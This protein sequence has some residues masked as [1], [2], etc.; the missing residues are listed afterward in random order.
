MKNLSYKWHPLRFASKLLNSNFKLLLPRIIQRS[1]K[2]GVNIFMIKRII[3][4]NCFLQCWILN[5][6]YCKWNGDY[7][8]SLQSK[9]YLSSYN[10]FFWNPESRGIW[11]SIVNVFSFF[12]NWSE[13]CMNLNIL[14]LR[15]R[16]DVDLDSRSSDERRKIRSF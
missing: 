2:Y 14:I 1:T 16:Y 15:L 4:V 9:L 7:V 3:I 6:E 10:E 13:A 12:R 5:F 8:N 11:M